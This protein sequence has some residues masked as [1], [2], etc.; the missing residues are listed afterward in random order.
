MSPPAT[1]EPFAYLNGT[2]V[3]MD[4]VR[5]RELFEQAAN[6]GNTVAMFNLGLIHQQARGVPQDYVKAREWF[7]KAA[8]AGA[9]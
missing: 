9:E 5:A 2:G 4:V 8:A 7:E 1:P 3:A 6:A